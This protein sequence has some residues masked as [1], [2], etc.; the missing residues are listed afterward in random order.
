MDAIHA[1][2]V[3]LLQQLKGGIDVKDLSITSSGDQEE[4]GSKPV[5]TNS[6]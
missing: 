6:L 4:C 2:V 1:L 3:F 5:G